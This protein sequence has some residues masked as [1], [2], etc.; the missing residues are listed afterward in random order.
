MAFP[1]NNPKAFYIIA[2]AKMSSFEFRMRIVSLSAD[3][4]LLCHMVR[5]FRDLKSGNKGLSN[6][7]RVT[8]RLPRLKENTFEKLE[9]EKKPRPLH[10]VEEQAKLWKLAAFRQPPKAVSIDTKDQVFIN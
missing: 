1:A 5:I 3:Y 6:R 9:L 4:P 2:N 10:P 8:K 7:K